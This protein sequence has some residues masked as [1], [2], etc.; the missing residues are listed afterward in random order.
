MKAATFLAVIMKI[1]TVSNTRMDDPADKTA[2]M[3]TCGNDNAVKQKVV[4]ILRD[5]GCA[6]EI[7]TGRITEAGWPEVMVRLWVRTA[8]AVNSWNAMFRVVR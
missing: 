2:E 7:D 5:S 1:N 6:G 4:Q 3:L 8:G